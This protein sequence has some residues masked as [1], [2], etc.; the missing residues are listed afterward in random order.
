MHI[1]PCRIR[2]ST[3]RVRTI[4]LATILGGACCGNAFGEGGDWAVFRGPNNDLTPADPDR[5][6]VD[7]WGEQGPVV[8]WTI[9]NLGAT[10][11][12]ASIVDGRVYLFDRDPRR[13]VDVLRCVRLRDGN[14]LW[15]FAYEA[16]GKYSYECARAT[17]AVDDRNVY[18]TGITG[19][20]HAVD[21]RTGREVWRVDLCE[22]FDAKDFHD[23]NKA[24]WDVPV[25]Y[26]SSVIPWGRTVLTA[27]QG[28]R[29]GLAAF[30]KTDGRLVWKTPPLSPKM[31]HASPV[32]LPVAGR[33]QIVMATWRN[34][35]G[36]DPNDGTILWQTPIRSKIRFCASPALISKDRLVLVHEAFAP[37]V[38]KVRRDGEEWSAEPVAEFDFHCG[39]D[40][41]PIATGGHLYM[42][43]QHGYK[44]RK[45]LYCVEIGTW[46]RKWYEP[47]DPKFGW[48]PM[49]LA[50]GKL[51]SLSQDGMLRLIEATPHG[52]RELARHDYRMGPCFG[53][54]AMS[55]GLLIARSRGKTL[56]IDL[57]VD[58]AHPTPARQAHR[59]D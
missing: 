59:G 47:G 30:D 18:I 27:P 44:S 43:C 11:S 28:P 5:P 7:G 6:I 40:F 31:S 38:V 56:C 51:I 52:Y 49:L 35:A 26:S 3:Y 14:V 41:R 36:I 48:G 29:A 37:Q 57:N 39:S 45:G 46:K 20:M 58:A 53:H 34:C 4:L 12:G 2:R 22:R 21:R 16:P 55:R 17:P 54:L 23:P 24:E 13:D 10:A 25:G 1:N 33:R 15:T 9:R 42:L 32:I 50:D 19:L 8:R